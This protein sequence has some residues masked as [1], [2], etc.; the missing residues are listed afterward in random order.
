MKRGLIKKLA[1]GGILTAL[2]FLATYY[3]MV[4]FPPGYFNLGDVVIIASVLALDWKIGIVSA[5]LGSALADVA[6]GS[7]AIYAPFTF[8]IKGL[9]AL[10]VWLVSMPADRISKNRIVMH[11]TNQSVEKIALTGIGKIKAVLRRLTPVVG[12]AAILLLASIM[13]EIV[14]IGGYFAAD[15]I[16]FGVATAVGGL[17]IPNTFQAVAGAV[18]GFLLGLILRK[19][20][21]RNL[22]E[23]PKKQA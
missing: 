9:M 13:G 5:A 8:V 6:T 10:I 4:P 1:V 12:E 17:I 15:T 21:L 7:F 14:M 11:A 19:L 16:L 2:V 22:I 20:K 23:P 18:G 3:L